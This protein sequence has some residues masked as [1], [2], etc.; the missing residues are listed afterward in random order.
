MVCLFYFGESK[1]RKG[2]FAKSVVQN[3]VLSSVSFRQHN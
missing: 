2:Y 1:Y 3:T